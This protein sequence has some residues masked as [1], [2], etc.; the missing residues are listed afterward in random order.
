MEFSGHY[1]IAVVLGGLERLRQ[2]QW[3]EAREGVAR[4]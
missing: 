2:A 1:C 3:R 4:M